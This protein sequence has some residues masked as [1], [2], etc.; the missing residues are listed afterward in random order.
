M[1]TARAASPRRVLSVE[2]SRP[3]RF[4]SSIVLSLL[5]FAICVSIQTTAFGQAARK[6]PA[7]ERIVGD[8][9]KASGGKK[10]VAAIRDAVFE[11]KVLAEGHEAG[12]ARTQTKW[13]AASRLDLLTARGE[14]VFA[15]NGRS[16]WR[17]DGQGGLHTLTDREAGAAK[18]Q[19]TL[20]ATRLSDYKKQ[21]VLARTLALEEAGAGEPAYV[22]EFSTR[23]GARLRYWFGAQTKLLRKVA[24]ETGRRTVHYE[25][26][27]QRDGLMLPQRLRLEGPD[28]PPLTLTLQS[29]RFNTG[30]LDALFDP[31]AAATLD[32][33]ALVR[34]LARNQALADKR[35]NDYT[36]TSKVTERKVNERGEVTKENVNIYDVYPVAGWGWVMKRVSENGVPLSPADAAREEKRVAEQLEKAEREAPE[37]ERKRREK[38][39]ERAA[40]QK[41]ERAERGDA[42]E[43]EDEA[44]GAD[45]GIAA[46]LRACEFVSPRRERF[47]EREAIVFDFRPRSGFRPSNRAETII[48]KLVGVVWIDP[49]DRQVVRLEARFAEGFKI[50]GGLLASI[51]PGAA[52]VFE[53]TRLA[54]GVWLPRFSQANASVKLLLFAGTTINETHEFSN[55]KRFSTETKDA[56]LDAP[57][58][59]SKP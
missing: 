8:Y 18:L 4:A 52:F 21:N 44:G 16:A 10:R 59:A 13:P 11:W 48:A 2:A 58:A 43:S 51:K 56:T 12:T 53:Q 31:P 28:A 33:P 37:R 22:V 40:R 36:F 34:E 20:E 24:D 42:G 1:E 38:A 23:E 54:D 45:V 57:P 35:I 29:A 26:Y 47:R 32:V 49:V 30:A 17:R 15:S 3:S 41:K 27:R 46:F 6:L 9:L 14:T 7:P 55:Y 19:A 50:G 5:V 25:D 39:A